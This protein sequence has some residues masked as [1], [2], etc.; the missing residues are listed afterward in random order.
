MYSY[1]KLFFQFYKFIFG[2][3][4]KQPLSLN[5]YSYYLSRRLPN[6][7]KYFRCRKC[8]N[9]SLRKQCRGFVILSPEGMAEKQANHNCPDV[10][11]E[12]IDLSITESKAKVEYF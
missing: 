8:S 2:K 9:G 4:T 3:N 7:R 10:V 6:G 5:G 12:S 1:R 11:E